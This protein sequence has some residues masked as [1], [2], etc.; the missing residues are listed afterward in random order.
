MSFVISK[1]KMEFHADTNEKNL[2]YS[3]VG[4]VYIAHDKQQVIGEVDVGAGINHFIGM[5]HLYCPGVPESDMPECRLS[6]EWDGDGETTD[7]HLINHGPPDSGQSRGV[8]TFSFKEPLLKVAL[9]ILPNQA[10]RN[11]NQPF[12][13][14]ANTQVLFSLSPQ[15]SALSHLSFTGPSVPSSFLGVEVEVYLGFDGS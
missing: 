6:A 8:G 7:I 5:V 15:D 12:T 4:E 11:S 1:N 10:S 2:A 13:I 9:L 3:N 14:P